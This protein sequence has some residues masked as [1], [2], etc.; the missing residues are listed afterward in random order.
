LIQNATTP[1]VVD[2]LP[3]NSL[4]FVIVS[5]EHNALDLADFLPLRYALANK[6]IVCLS[7]SFREEDFN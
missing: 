4:D 1:A 5:A 6:G 7:T 3:D 2:F